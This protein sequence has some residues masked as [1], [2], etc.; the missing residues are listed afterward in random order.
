MGL[1]AGA[2]PAGAATLQPCESTNPTGPIV[3]LDGQLTL[4]PTRAT[5]K[6]WKR[7]GIRQKLVRPANNLTGRPA[8]PV[9]KVS[10]ART[11]RVDLKGGIK[12]GRGK[13][14]VVIRQFKVIS[15][16]GKPAYLRGKLGKRSFN[17]FVI[18]GGK[19]TFNR[20]SGELTRIG[21]AR[22]TPKGAKLLNRRL[23][24]RGKKR[25]RAGTVWGYANLYSLYKVTQVE[26]PTGEPPPVPPVKEEPLGASQVTGAATIKWY[27][28]DTFIDYVASGQGTRAEDGATADPPT[29]P[30][31]LSYSYN[32]PFASGWT[33]PAAGE[34]PENTLIKGTG[35][36]GFK[37]CKNTINFTVSAPEI[38]IDGDDNSRM[39]FHV[40]GTDGT[41]FPNQRAIMVKLVPGMADPPEVTVDGATTT[42]SY[43]R[44]P[45][46]V[47]AEG[48]SLFADLY[49]PYNPAFEGQN[50]RPD[51]FGSLSI[52]YTFT[53]GS[54]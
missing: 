3:E 28:R 13:R 10:Y 31:N 54:S 45:G 14:S 9:R 53:T 23:G 22:L 24:L 27:V 1:G 20:K 4:A 16:A 37:Y 12:V 33:V 18:R 6:A 2:A 40:N 42:V 11:A 8:F 50:P 38:E 5:R 36:V 52:T 26:D 49:P 29:G 15:R 32:F 41:P 30:N 19:R 43:D 34:T 48:A 21:G 44:I 47:P 46:F 51:R 39:I 17:V 35:L 25:L 7:S